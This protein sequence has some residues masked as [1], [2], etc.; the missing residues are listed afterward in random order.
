MLI[1][2]NIIKIYLMFVKNFQNQTVYF[3]NGYPLPSHMGN[4]WFNCCGEWFRVVTCSSNSRRFSTN[5]RIN[6]TKWK[7]LDLS[8]ILTVGK[9]NESLLSKRSKWNFPSFILMSKSKKTW[10]HVYQNFLYLAVILSDR[11]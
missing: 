8:G 3:S 5:G 11:Y 9:G 4:K 1:L 2:T 6:Y 10:P 7:L